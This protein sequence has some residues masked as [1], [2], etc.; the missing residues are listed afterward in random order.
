MFPLQ[1]GEGGLRFSHKWPTLKQWQLHWN[2]II[3]SYLTGHPGNASEELMGNKQMR[4]TRSPPAK[5]RVELQ[6]SVDSSQR[7][8]SSGKLSS[9]RTLQS[10][11]ASAG[12]AWR[13]T[14]TGQ[15]VCSQ[16]FII[17]TI[18]LPSYHLYIS[19][20]WPENTCLTKKKKYQ[21]RL[22]LMVN[23]F[24]VYHILCQTYSSS[25]IIFSLILVNVPWFR[26]TVNWELS[27]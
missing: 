26:D 14:G 5:P 18:M 13:G 24:L 19:N 23:I 12:R 4:A 21:E 7:D 11:Q 22:W 6:W 3:C 2:L 9:Q 10:G 17:I 1:E 15:T 16:N 8:L 25:I 20:D 27:T